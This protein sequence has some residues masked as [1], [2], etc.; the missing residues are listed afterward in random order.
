MARNLW[1]SWDVGMNSR[2]LFQA[3]FLYIEPFPFE[4]FLLLLT[5]SVRQTLC[6]LDKGIQ[7]FARV[8]WDLFLKDDFSLVNL[9]VDLVNSDTHCSLPM[10]KLP[11][12]RHHSTISRKGRVVDIDATK[13]WKSNQWLFKDRRSR[14][15]NNKVKIL[16]SQFIQKFRLM[17]AIL[18]KDINVLGPA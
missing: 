5:C 13:P 7:R 18:I 6:S 2:T 17:E 12:I 10:V 14:Y 1:T 8:D 16:S 3:Y 4:S 11:E 9:W 15:R